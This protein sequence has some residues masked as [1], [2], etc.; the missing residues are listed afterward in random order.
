MRKK[1]NGG[2]GKERFVERELKTLQSYEVKLEEM[3]GG[4]KDGD[5]ESDEGEK[6]SVD[7][8]EKKEEKKS[9]G[10]KRRHFSELKSVKVK[11]ARLSNVV[12]VVS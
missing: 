6:Q 2:L 1:K 10:V 5:Q 3:E 12:E 7:E 9:K 8:G 4:N 11:Q